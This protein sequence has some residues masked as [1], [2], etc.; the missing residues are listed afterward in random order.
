MAWG[1]PEHDGGAA[2]TAYRL[3]ARLDG[4]LEELPPGAAAGRWLGGV[5]EAGDG[6][7]MQRLG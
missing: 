2:L 7:G 3:E 4:R 6:V 5:V 1:K